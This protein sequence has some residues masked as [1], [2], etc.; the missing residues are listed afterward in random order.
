MKKRKVRA[1]V[2]KD[3]EGVNKETPGWGTKTQ[4][5]RNLPQAG[6]GKRTRLQLQG[7]EPVLGLSGYQDK[8]GIFGQR[9]RRGM[10]GFGK[11]LT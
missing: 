9:Q 8:E 2:L 4:G 5:F 7:G 11:H 10:G 3:M 1:G 6:G